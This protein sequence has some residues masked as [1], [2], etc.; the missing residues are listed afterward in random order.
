MV[1]QKSPIQPMPK[2]VDRTV[3]Y[4]EFLLKDKN[5]EYSPDKKWFDLEFR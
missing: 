3:N 1:T 4:P 5:S 2:L